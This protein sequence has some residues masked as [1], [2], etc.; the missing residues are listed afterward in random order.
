LRVGD[1]AALLIP[2]WFPVP[3]HL[4]IGVTADSLAEATELATSVALARGWTL[5]A[6]LVEQNV[7]L[8][9]LGLPEALDIGRS[10]VWFP[11]LPSAE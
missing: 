9:Q 4:G 10:G 11:V 5:D 2:F 7:Q 8:G 3:G 1:G 6:R